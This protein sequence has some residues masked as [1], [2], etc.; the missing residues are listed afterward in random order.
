MKKLISLTLALISVLICFSSCNNTPDTTISNTS[1][2]TTK[3]EQK[4]PNA[5]TEFEDKFQVSDGELVY[6]GFYYYDG[7]VDVN[8]KKMYPVTLKYQ[9]LNNLQSEGA[10]LYNDVLGESDDPFVSDN[11]MGYEFLVDETATRE[12]GGMPV[13]IISIQTRMEDI[14]AD[15]NIKYFRLMSYNTATGKVKILQDDIEYLNKI[16]L[17]NDR[18]YIVAREWDYSGEEPD[19]IY[20]LYSMNRDGTDIRKYELKEKNMLLEII[21]VFRGMIYFKQ[22]GM[23]YKTNYEFDNPVLIFNDMNCGAPI[24]FSQ[25]YMYYFMKKT[26]VTVQGKELHLSNLMRRP[27]S[28]ME[29]PSSAEIVLEDIYSVVRGNSPNLYYCPIVD[30]I[31]LVEK[32][33]KIYASFACFRVFDIK[34]GQSYILYDKRDID[35]D[36][37]YIPD[38]FTEDIY[39]YTEDRIEKF[40]NAKTGEVIFEGDPF[41]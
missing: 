19:R 8:Q 25:G 41:V 23:I 22:G 14:D 29:D 3:N 38:F 13:L 37:T 16:Y 2:P 34:T 7:K 36:N 24:V 28:T 11:I 12:N 27:L 6:N 33:S 21:G 9:N 30:E 5:P 15:S 1:A 32:Y 39:A 4:N 10:R 31:K 26:D 40:F 18:L 20:I 35:T 17:I